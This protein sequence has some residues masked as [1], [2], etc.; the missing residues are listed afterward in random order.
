MMVSRYDDSNFL[1]VLQIDH[2]RVAGYLASHWV[3]VYSLTGPS[4]G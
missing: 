2:S 1:L 3:T 4:S